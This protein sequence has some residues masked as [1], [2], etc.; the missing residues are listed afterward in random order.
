MAH[1]GTW[2]RLGSGNLPTED[3]DEG[4]GHIVPVPT[5]NAVLA[6]L[7]ALTIVTVA[8]AAV[9][10]G[11]FSVFVALL[12]ATIKSSLVVMYFMHVKFEKPIIVILVIYPLVILA[13]MILGTLGDATVREQVR[14]FEALSVQ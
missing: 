11:P 8:V 9:D 14:P 5:Y 12:I 13:L 10:F 6:T 3:M 1:H 7:M 2:K 4:L